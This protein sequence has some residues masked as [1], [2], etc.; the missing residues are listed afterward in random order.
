VVNNNLR[1]DSRNSDNLQIVN[2]T[3]NYMY[4]AS[5]IS[6]VMV[7][8]LQCLIEPYRVSRMIPLLMMTTVTI[9]MT[10]TYNSV[11]TRVALI[12]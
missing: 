1:V 8:N 7:L 5:T 3:A 11:M 10:I 12:R 2:E 9:E 6:V 4:N